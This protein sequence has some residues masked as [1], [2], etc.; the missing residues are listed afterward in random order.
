MALTRP[1][2]AASSVFISLCP[3]SLAF[4]RVLAAYLPHALMRAEGQPRLGPMVPKGLLVMLLL[5]LLR[6]K[7]LALQALHRLDAR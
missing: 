3:D 6:L 5:Q 1:Y 4:A 7:N 2:E